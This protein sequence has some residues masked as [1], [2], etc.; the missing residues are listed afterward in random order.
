[1]GGEIKHEYSLIKG[2]AVKVP[3][4]HASKLGD[5]ENVASVEED[6]EVHTT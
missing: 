5:H 2:F 4:V 1:M 3:A 6:K